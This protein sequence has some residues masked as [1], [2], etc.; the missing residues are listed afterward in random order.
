MGT[1]CC[2]CDPN[3][4]PLRQ[5]QFPLP[6]GP[7]GPNG[8]GA[9]GQFGGIVQSPFTNSRP[10]NAGPLPSVSTSL[11]V[12]EPPL[13]PT[14]NHLQLQQPAGPSNPLRASQLIA[15]EAS[16]FVLNVQDPEGTNLRASRIVE[17]HVVPG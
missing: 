9:G 1:V 7:Y 4:P 6:A 15:Q 14:S 10:I 3:S 5:Y 13:I 11:G 16:G 8:Y 2:E 12:A 17:D